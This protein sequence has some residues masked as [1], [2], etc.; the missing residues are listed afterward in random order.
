MSVYINKEN[1]IDIRGNKYDHTIDDNVANIVILGSQVF[2]ILQSVPRFE[3]I[4]FF[5]IKST[6]CVVYNS[7]EN[8]W[9]N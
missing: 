4:G 8:E 9:A 3:R 7:A 5:H 2:F 1:T 6:I